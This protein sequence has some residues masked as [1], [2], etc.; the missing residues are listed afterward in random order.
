MKVQLQ[1]EISF[2]EKVYERADYVDQKTDCGIARYMSAQTLVIVFRATI[3]T[4]PRDIRA[5]LDADRVLWEGIHVHHGFS[6]SVDAVWPT[7]ISWIREAGPEINAVHF[8]GHSRGGSQA[9]LATWK[10]TRRMLPHDTTGFA[11]EPARAV[12]WASARQVNKYLGT[13]I[14]WTRNDQDIITHSAPWISGYSH[15]GNRIQL[16]NPWNWLTAF[17]GDNWAH[18]LPNVKKNIAKE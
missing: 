10:L 15:V 3:P 2:S 5:D 12:S 7:I 8:T 9:I 14:Q 16:G 6:E 11:I 13:K 18:L 4:D 17:G 1:L